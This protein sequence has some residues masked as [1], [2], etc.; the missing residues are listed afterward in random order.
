M[1]RAAHGG[2]ANLARSFSEDGAFSSGA[3]AHMA[4]HLRCHLRLWIVG[5]CAGRLQISSRK[6]N[7]KIF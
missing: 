4:L 7:E 3:Q 1:L 2:L 6:H 5:C